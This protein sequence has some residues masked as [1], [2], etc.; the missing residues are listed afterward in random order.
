MAAVSGSG[1]TLTA[2]W[3]LTGDFSASE[4]SVGADADKRLND[5]A[6]EAPASVQVGLDSVLALSESGGREQGGVGGG[7]KS[8]KEA[9][10]PLPALATS[11]EG[12]GSG[13][14]SCC[15]TE[16]I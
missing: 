9:G 1:A 12:V 4:Q 3:R 15:R 16:A 13:R 11:A 14:T 7:C 8:K 6:A 2:D 5:E 10:W